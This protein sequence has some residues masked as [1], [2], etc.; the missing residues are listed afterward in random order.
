MKLPIT[1]KKR[2]EYAIVDIETT[3]GNAQNSRITEIAIFIHNGEQLINQWQTLINPEIHIPAYITALTGIDNQTVQNAP[4]FLQ[5]APQIYELLY[6]KIFVAHHVNFDYSFVKHQLQQSGYSWHAVKCCTVRLARKVFPGLS[7]YSLGNLCNSLQI[8]IYNRHRAAGDAAATV[9]L[10]ERM[11]QNNKGIDVEYLQ[12]KSKVEQLLPPNLPVEVFNSLPQKTG[13]Y[14]FYNRVNKLIYVGKAINIKKRVLS[15]F[16]GH[17]ISSQR[18]QF[19]KEV[20]GISYKLTGTELMALL[21]EYQEITTLWPLYNKALKKFEPKFGLYLYTARNGYKYL[22]V[23][24]LNS[25]HHSIKVCCTAVAANDVLRHLANRFDIDNSYCKYLTSQTINEQQLTIKQQL[26]CIHT[27]N[28][29]VDEAIAYLFKNQQSYFISEEGCTADEKSYILIENG[30]LYGWG[31]IKKEKNSAGLEEIKKFIK[32]TKSSAY[33]MQL[34][35][36]Y[37][38]QFPEKV[39]FFHAVNNI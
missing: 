29:K 16:T 4:T 18:Q 15:H 10:F 30:Q 24:R 36:N 12:H 9:L 14:Y 17:K 39:T 37:I 21:L 31:Y 22:A 33:I 38:Q 2:K 3:G 35:T 6:D 28:K 13:V 8:P 25:Q 34:L 23:M 27:H 19:L 20:H 7:S 32:P 1:M 11:L 26:P 5:V